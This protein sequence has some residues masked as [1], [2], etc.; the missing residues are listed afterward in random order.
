M[1][2]KIVKEVKMSDIIISPEYLKLIEEVKQLKED[3]AGTTHIDNMDILEPKLF[4]GVE[5]QFLENPIINMI[6]RQ[7]L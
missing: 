1:K 4:E 6:A 2:I 3:I 5:V 7:L